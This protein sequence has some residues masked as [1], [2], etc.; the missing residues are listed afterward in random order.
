MYVQQAE[1][2]VMQ[3]LVALRGLEEKKAVTIII[4]GDT[5]KDDRVILTGNGVNNTNVKNLALQLKEEMATMQGSGGVTIRSKQRY[6]LEDERLLTAI[7][8]MLLDS[9]LLVTFGTDHLGVQWGF[10]G[11]EGCMVVDEDFDKMWMGGVLSAAAALMQYH[12]RYAELTLGQCRGLVFKG[13]FQKFGSL[14]FPKIGIEIALGQVG[15]STAWHTVTISELTTFL[16]QQVIGHKALLG[17]LTFAGRVVPFSLMDWPHVTVAGTNT[18]LQNALHDTQ[19]C[20]TQVCLVN[21]GCIFRPKATNSQKPNCWFVAVLSLFNNLPAL[22]RLLADDLQAMVVDNG[23]C[24][25]GRMPPGFL[26]FCQHATGISDFGGGF[27]QIWFFWLML[28][29]RNPTLD[30][31]P[32]FDSVDSG[33]SVAYHSQEGVFGRGMWSWKLQTLKGKEGKNP[34]KLWKHIERTIQGFGAIAGLLDLDAN[35]QMG[36]A[37]T[38]T[39]CQGHMVVCHRGT[40]ASRD[41]KTQWAELFGWQPKEATNAIWVRV[42][43]LGIVTPEQRKRDP[44]LN[45]SRRELKRQKQQQ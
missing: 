28:R 38:F 7:L 40:C 11:Y 24:E 31:I 21:P 42:F 6:T 10:D 1:Q 29:Y 32:V 18:P 39:M 33:D 14:R 43:M 19:Q 34:V 9:Q 37:V 16:K 35:N 45:E 17:C 13:A 44:P 4:H 3:W 30:G 26:A 23:D 5:E 12:Y 27:D 41:S 2:V 8:P 22:R 20:D 25:V 36:H 15:F